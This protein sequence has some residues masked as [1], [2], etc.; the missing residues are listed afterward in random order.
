[1]NPA[2]TSPEP[3]IAPYAMQHRLALTALVAD[4]AFLVLAMGSVVASNLRL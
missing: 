2:H 1:M 4:V 3:G